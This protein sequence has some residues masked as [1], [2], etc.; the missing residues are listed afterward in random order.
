M[1]IIKSIS[2]IKNIISGEDSFL[3]G[4]MF[5]EKLYMKNRV[6]LFSVLILGSLSFFVYIGINYY[7]SF[8]LEKANKAYN[9]LMKNSKDSSAIKELES[10][11]NL[12]ETYQFMKALESKNFDKLN[13]NSVVLSD[14]LKFQS[15][16][17]SKNPDKILEYANSTSVLRDYALLQASMLYIDNKKYASAR[18]TLKKITND[19]RIKKNAESLEHFLITKVK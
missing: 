14:I 4:G 3:R 5:L 9:K 1:S 8:A 13:L 7:N 11:K 18:R 12:Y 17:S 19:S 16:I 10:N 6:L 15:V 2:E